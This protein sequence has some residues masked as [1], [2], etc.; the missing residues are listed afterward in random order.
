[1]KFLDL[2]FFEFGF[3]RPS[4]MVL[5][6]HVTPEFLAHPYI[7]GCPHLEIHWVE[8]EAEPLLNWL[9]APVADGQ[10]IFGKIL[11]F[12]RP[13]ERISETL[14]TKIRSG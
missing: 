7:L 2:D 8:F 1:M 5:Y 12:E 13:L 6:R 10:V 11:K 4:H 3:F 14:Q 9:R